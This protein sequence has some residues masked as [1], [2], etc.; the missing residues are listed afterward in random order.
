MVNSVHFEQERIE[1]N[2]LILFFISG[3]SHFLHTKE[4]ELKKCLALLR[5]EPQL[6]AVVYS[7][8]LFTS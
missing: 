8:R 1:I 2:N 6:F 5:S 7:K 3:T 4:N